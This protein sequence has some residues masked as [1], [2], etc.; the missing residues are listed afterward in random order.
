MSDAEGR[1]LD[2]ALPFGTWT[3]IQQKA[4][5]ADP[6][7]PSIEGYVQEALVFGLELL[8]VVKENHAQGVDTSLYV[9]TQ[10]R[11]NDLSRIEIKAWLEGIAEAGD[12]DEGVE[13]VAD[14][15]P[16]MNLAYYADPAIAEHLLWF[17]ETLGIQKTQL[18][19][20]LLTAYSE[21]C[22]HHS[23]GSNV[24]INEGPEEN[25][26]FL[27]IEVRPRGEVADEEGQ[28]DD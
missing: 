23:E 1:T 14:D 11:P 6:N 28:D 3:D 27:I 2:F 13:S 10:H 8:R 24:Y 20:L 16:T 18:V 25:F 12:N 22:I 26:D 19:A 15:D 21:V 17:C 7:D 5:E 9:Q 4:Y